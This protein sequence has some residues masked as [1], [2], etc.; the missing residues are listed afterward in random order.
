MCQK[1]TPGF[2][3]SRLIVTLALEAMRIVEEGIAD[4]DDVDLAC[5][6]A[7]NHA[8]GPIDT[9]DYSGLDTDAARGRQHA[10]HLRR[11]LP[12]APEP[13]RARERRAAR[14]QERHAASRA[15][16]RRAER[17]GAVT[18]EVADAVATVTVDNPPVNALD[19]P[20]LEGLGDA[21]RAGR[22]RRRACAQSC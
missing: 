11:A 10:P 9:M 22:R 7:F 1:D 20:T 8:M 18:V 16:S 3:T 14:A 15:T 5:V 12:G 19:D 21:A 6:K 2:I 17:A 13:A 4:P